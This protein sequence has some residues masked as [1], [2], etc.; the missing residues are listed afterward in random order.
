M[1]KGFKQLLLL[2]LLIVIELIPAVIIITKLIKLTEG[3]GYVGTFLWIFV[4]IIAFLE[5]IV[6]AAI[7]IA[8]VPKRLNNCISIILP[9]L[10][11]LL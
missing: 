3:M 1:D 6:N 4:G 2:N 5:E 11:R 8:I 7:N 10:N 9:L